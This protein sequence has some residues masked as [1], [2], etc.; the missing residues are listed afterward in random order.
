MPRQQGAECPSS[1]GQVNT[2][3]EAYVYLS[4]EAHILRS[5]SFNSCLLSSLSHHLWIF[6]SLPCSLFC[7]SGTPV[8]SCLFNLFPAHS[9]I[10]HLSIHWI[11][12]LDL[13]LSYS[14]LCLQLNI[15]YCVTCL[16]SIL[17]LSFKIQW[18]YFSFLDT[19]WFLSF[20]MPCFHMVLNFYFLSF[21]KDSYFYR[22][23]GFSIAWN[24][25]ESC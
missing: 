16:L 4:S 12:W 7:L 15:I 6:T 1:F 14:L 3:R 17:M 23:S 21:F 13:A 20:F 18:L 11:L 9:F 22:V 19:I 25:W 10:V 8:C 24:I 5:E 2:Y